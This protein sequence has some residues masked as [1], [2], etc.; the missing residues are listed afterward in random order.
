MNTEYK[1]Y[2]LDADALKLVKGNLNLIKNKNVILTPHEGELKIM[3]GIELSA[4][5]EIEE[6]SNEILKLAQDIGVTILVKGPYDYISDGKNLKIN[7]TGCPEMSIGGTGDVLAGL[8][9]CFLATENNAFKSACS[10]AFFN[11]ILGE[12]CKAKIG[13]RF[14]AFDMTNNINKAIQSVLNS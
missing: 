8:C 4:Y 14:T 9:T 5:D 12:Y 3:T 13:N 11:G 7:R 1:N 6:R 10:A 2:V